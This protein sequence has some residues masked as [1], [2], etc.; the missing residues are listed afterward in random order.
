MHK[1]RLNL[2]KFNQSLIW[3]LSFFAFIFLNTGSA[4]AAW[5]PPAQ[6]PPNGNVAPPIYASSTLLQE[7]GGSGYGGQLKLNN[8]QTEDAVLQLQTTANNS[9]WSIYSMYSGAG[10]QN[11]HMKYDGNPILTVSTDGKIGVASSTP[12]AELG[13]TGSAL[14]TGAIDIGTTGSFGGNVN[15]NNNLIQNIGDPLTDFTAGG[16]LNLQGELN[17]A[18]DTS[19]AS[20][21][22][23]RLN[24]SNLLWVTDPNSTSTI[25][26]D[27]WIKNGLKL[28]PASA[29][30]TQSG[31]SFT[32]DVEISTGNGD[33]V[34]DPMGSVSFEIPA[35]ET[36]S[37][38][39]ASN[40]PLF[41][42]DASTNDITLGRDSA[43]GQ[44]IL[45]LDA[46][47]G[48]MAVG[49]TTPPQYPLDLSDDGT[50]AIMNLQDS[51]GTLF[52]GARLE[53]S[54]EQWFVGMKGE[55]NDLVF[56]PNQTTANEVVITQDGK[57]GIGT[58]SPSSLLTVGNSNQFTVDAAGNV[59]ATT[60]SGGFEVDG[61]LN[62]Q[63]N[64]IINTS[65]IGIG[66]ITPATQL[67]VYG[68]ASTT[69][70]VVAGNTT[71]QG[72][73]TTSIPFI[74]S[75]GVLD[76]DLEYMNYDQASHT[77]TLE[78]LTV[79]ATSTL[80]FFE[81]K[82]D[83][84]KAETGQSMRFLT[85]D[86]ERLTI[87]PDGNL[88]INDSSPNY[89][90]DIAATSTN[91][92]ALSWSTSA[93]SVRGGLWVD[94]DTVG[95]GSVTNSGLGFFTADGSYSMV[96]DTAGNVGIATTTPGKL[97]TIG[98]NASISN[99]GDANFEGDLLVDSGTLYVAS[100]TN[101]VGIGSSSPSELFSV[102]NSLTID[103]GGNI[104]TSGI[105]TGSN[106]N[107]TNWDMA[108][109]W[110]NHS[111][112]YVPAASYYATTTHLNINSLPSLSI[113]E[114]QVS[115]LRAYLTENQVITIS[116]DATGTGTTSVALSFNDDSVSS[117]TLNITN[118]WAQGQFLSQDGSGELSWGDTT[119]SLEGLTDTTITST[120][121]GQILRL[122]ASGKWENTSNVSINSS[123]K[124]GIGI[125]DP[126][127]LLH[128]VTPVQ[129]DGFSTTG[130][131]VVASM[132]G[133][134][135]GVAAPAAS[136]INLIDGTS[137][138]GD[139]VYGSMYQATPFNVSLIKIWSGVNDPSDALG[140]KD[141]KFQ[142][143]TDTTDGTDGSWSDLVITDMI[144][145][146]SPK[147]GTAIG[148]DG[149]RTSTFGAN[150]VILSGNKHDDL[151]KDPDIIDF[152]NVDNV[153]GVRIVVRT[154]WYNGLHTNEKPHVSEME[155]YEDI[156]ALYINDVNANVGIGTTSPSTALEV[157]GTVTATAFAGDGSALTGV[158]GDA[159]YDSSASSP[160]DTVWV[161]DSGNVGVGTTTPADTLHVIGD[162]R[163]GAAGTSGCIKAADGTNIA[164][165]CSSDVR[166]K[167][168]IK[169]INNILDK[170]LNLEVVNYKWRQNEFPEKH[171]GNSI[172][173]GL[174][175]QDVE[176]IMPELVGVD[177]SGYKTVNYSKLSIM[178]LKALQELK[179]KTEQDFLS[180]KALKE[181]ESQRP[182]FTGP[183]PQN[184]KK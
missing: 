60:F 52:T 33:I 24:I 40:Q 169:P 131:N 89:L 49:T 133:L 74:N 109:S 82:T 77:L 100:S 50:T 51:N 41:S 29:Y 85:N 111:G 56:R 43:T 70:L 127:G 139:D 105:I 172:Q 30:F 112:Q 15:L 87:L 157:N 137:Y 93:G 132:D 46:N 120:S 86:T 168:D 21:S 130:N 55:D 12:A 35:G 140:A 36:Y 114:S 17:V 22:I 54:G 160:A 164:G 23:S 167:K 175:A 96:I 150:Y 174:I 9:P 90:I 163:V 1:H 116:G 26:N 149:N 8:L 142:Y 38:L 59:T 7:I 66:T 62:M 16:G 161:N 98:E 88:G 107:A 115:D 156:D 34:F 151:S 106:I 126:G 2:S 118:Q 11:L 37:V 65:N 101:R 154:K 5:V 182:N 180:L 13:V 155:I 3:C 159:S 158:G 128:A 148:Y 170:M 45:F 162:I 177:D 27:L 147:E 178:L 153:K 113:T 14:I 80:S 135:D 183:L 69:N 79:N 68:T 19:L 99:G 124:V 32:S 28:G 144:V 184:I 146:Q 10:A 71:L 6:D 48:Q 4:S 138:P 117:S 136:W 18:D 145:S 76:D 61:V 165:S 75:S 173:T 39:N 129:V 63:N 42:L 171:F 125:T 143:S 57:L 81:I 102:A 104:D 78:N 67:E 97:L 141:V 25:E 64:Q 166:F 20:T 122:A 92:H 108:Y 47:S 176:E 152:D 91:Q 121:S 83:S 103:A 134:A 58:T 31:M 72:L 119:V 110:G 84:I 73:A 94:E 179:E 181:S 95:F 44:P 53:R 123:G